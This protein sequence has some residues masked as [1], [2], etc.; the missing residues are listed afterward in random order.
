MVKLTQQLKT[1][2]INKHYS[3]ISY[4]KTGF[5]YLF[6]LLALCQLVIN[7]HSLYFT[8]IR[9]T[10]SN[11]PHCSNAP[12]RQTLI[13]TLHKVTRFQA[14]HLQFLGRQPLVLWSSVGT[15]VSLVCVSWSYWT[16]TVFL[17]WSHSHKCIKLDCSLIVTCQ[18]RLSV[19]SHIS[20]VIVHQCK[21]KQL[22]TE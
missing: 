3:G 10:Q 16:L 4:T 2:N 11:T 7:L 5:V 13:H 17:T 6:Y 21:R 12:H 19:N 15:S 22:N 18:L 1:I 14:F 9:Y 8:C 20:C